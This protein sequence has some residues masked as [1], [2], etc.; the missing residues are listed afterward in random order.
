MLSLEV[1]A[2]IHIRVT[3]LCFWGR[4]CPVS[5]VYRIQRPFIIVPKKN[6][7]SV[8]NYLPKLEAKIELFCKRTQQNPV[9]V[10]QGPFDTKMVQGHAKICEMLVYNRFVAHINKIKVHKVFYFILFVLMEEPN[11]KVIIIYQ[12]LRIS[13][14]SCL[15]KVYDNS[16]IHTHFKKSKDQ[17]IF[18]YL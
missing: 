10:N 12:V 2:S 11:N 3:F 1:L 7:L 8:N 6:C 17:K 9:N 13:L 16:L 4:Q 14:L 5:I 15:Y 18:L